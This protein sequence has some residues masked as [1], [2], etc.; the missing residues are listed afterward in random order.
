MSAQL[1]QDEEDNR[2][3]QTLRMNP[4]VPHSVYGLAWSVSVD[5]DERPLLAMAQGNNVLVAELK[6]QKTSL[7]TPS[8]STPKNL[9]RTTNQHTMESSSLF[10]I[11]KFVVQPSYQTKGESVEMD[12]LAACAFFETEVGHPTIVAGGA[13]GT[14]HVLQIPGISSDQPAIPTFEVLPCGGIT[15][16]KVSPTCNWIIIVAYDDGVCRMWDMNQGYMI[17][18]FARDQDLL[19]NGLSSLDFHHSG[20]Q[21]VTGSEDSLVCIWQCGTIIDDYLRQQSTLPSDAS[22]PH[23]KIERWPLFCTTMRRYSPEN[24]VNEIIGIDCV[25][26]FNDLIMV[27]CLNVICLFHATI[28]PPLTTGK[29][30]IMEPS[31]LGVTILYQF[32]LDNVFFSLTKFHCSHQYIAAGNANGQVYLW[33][34]ERIEV[35]DTDDSD[36]DD[37]NSD[38][39]EGSTF[40]E[41]TR[42]L[43]MNHPITVRNV[44]FSPNGGLLATTTDDGFLCL[45]II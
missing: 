42:I 10:P 40:I 36:A 41:P 30:V 27:S 4:N 19:G 34:L 7:P 26:F 21:L 11:Y 2:P 32:R 25:Q 9:N 17:S 15:E 29:S 18:A 28:Q 23:C 22:M 3:A 13:N 38:N 33:D 45:W 37:S 12:I 14:L 39:S 6:D 31:E 35:S 24:A 43:S 1:K 8:S 16:I 5:G 20:N 44:R